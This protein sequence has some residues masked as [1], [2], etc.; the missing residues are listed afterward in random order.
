M[1]SLWNYK[2]DCYGSYAS[3]AACCL[4]SV[5]AT[6]RASSG[7]GSTAP[8]HHAAPS[9]R[10]GCVTHSSGTCGQQEARLDGILEAMEVPAG[11]MGAGRQGSGRKNPCKL[12]VVLQAFQVE[13][14]WTLLPESE[15][16]SAARLRQALPPHVPVREAGRHSTPIHPPG[17]AGL[18]CCK[19]RARDLT[20]REAET[21]TVWPFKEQRADPCVS[22]H[23]REHFRENR[24]RK[25]R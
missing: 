7:Q 8:C 10:E 24:G 17:T 1:Q 6:T 11:V 4:F 20:A 16:R 3:S 18:L 14:G 15:A 2:R 21:F 22:E 5:D 13:A 25:G 19:G 23:R 12:R 9:A